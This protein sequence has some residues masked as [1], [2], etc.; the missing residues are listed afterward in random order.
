MLRMRLLPDYLGNAIGRSTRKR[1]LGPSPCDE[2]VLP[3][4][5]QNRGGAQTGPVSENSNVDL[6]LLQ[7]LEFR[8]LIRSVITALDVGV[9][10]NGINQVVRGVLGKDHEIIDRHEFLKDFKAFGLIEDR[11]FLTLERTNTCIGIDSDDQH[12]TLIARIPEVGDMPGMNDVEASVGEHDPASI[13]T[14]HFEFE[15]KMLSRPD[16]SEPFARSQE[17]RS[18]QFGERHRL[19]SGKFNFNAGGKVRQPHGFHAAESSTTC[20]GQCR[21]HHVARTGD[22][23]DRPGVGRKMSAAI[24][25]RENRAVSVEGE[26]HGLEIVANPKGLR[27][28]GSQTEISL[29]LS[30]KSRGEFRLASVRGDQR[31][32]GVTAVVLD[33]CGVDQHRE[34]ARST[35]IDQPTTEVRRAGT[36]GIV[37]ETH[38]VDVGQP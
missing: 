7:Q 17:R 22:V 33:R 20:R 34:P 12:V 31:G 19:R 11:A 5:I 6:Q 29:Q 15:Q 16:L 18:S 35:E 10:A 3:Q 1:I 32:T 25:V 38:H 26:H 4:S 13:S 36:F 24:G 2:S 23:V 28:P 14:M 8:D 21:K 37:L 27:D 30:S 9:G